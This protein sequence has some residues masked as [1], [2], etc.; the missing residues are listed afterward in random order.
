MYTFHQ[1]N[2]DKELAISTLAI[3]KIMR[4][5]TPPQNFIKATDDPCS[6]GVG[7]PGLPGAVQ[8]HGQITYETRSPLVS[9]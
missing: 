9:L 3:C 8:T 4:R 6:E 1:V 7:S 5:T 2:N